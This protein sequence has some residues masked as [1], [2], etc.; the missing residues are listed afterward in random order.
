MP[1]PTPWNAARVRQVLTTESR[2]KA[3]DLF[4]RTHRP[5]RQIRVDLCKESDLAGRFISE[6]QV[7][8]MITAG[9]LDA[10]NRLFFVVGEAGAG[11]SEL[12]QWLEYRA[13]P[14][15]RLAI[16]IPRSMTSAAHVAALLRRA[17]GLA[18][19]PLLRRTPV[20]TQ[21]RHV[22]LS[23]AVLLYE[24]GDPSLMP[25]SEWEE[26]LD[27][28]GTRAAITEHL[29]AALHGDSGSRYSRPSSRC[30]TQAQQCGTTTAV[31]NDPLALR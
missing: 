2:Q 9:A 5:F 14:A 25:T 28:T 21:A 20:A 26:L 8:A 18:G 3:R 13:D 19:A 31:G 11:K 7:Y 29:T 6:E 15:C 1:Y 23:A 22:A 17:L 4:L 12:C 30:T 10:D 27:S 16:H 24:Q